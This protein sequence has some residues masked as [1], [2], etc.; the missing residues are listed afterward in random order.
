MVKIKGHEI[1][2]VVVKG[3]NNRRAIQFQNNIIT[4]LRKIGVTENDID[5]PLERLPM[6]KVNA[7]ATW[8]LGD[9]RMHYVHNMQK[10]FVENLY[11]LSRVIEIEA[12][13]VLTED[14]TIADFILEF[15][16]DK[17]VHKKR[18]EAREFFD[19]H[20][21]ETD[22]TIINEKYKLMA[23][24]LHPDKPT[25]DLEKFKQLNVAHKTLKRELT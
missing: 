18:Q 24:E 23:R 16:E 20:P 1:G 25:G 22:F 2:S 3:A 19:C 6:K 15:K 8:W 10:N 21:D 7:S 4:A 12:N 17:D 14:I 11:V 13:R 9:N 5:V